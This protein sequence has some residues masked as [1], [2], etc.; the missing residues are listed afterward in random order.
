MHVICCDEDT[1]LERYDEANRRLRECYNHPGLTDLKMN[2]LNSLIEGYGVEAII[3]PDDYSG[4]NAV[5][6]VNMG[7]TYTSTICHDNSTGEFTINCWGDFVETDPERFG[8]EY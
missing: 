7:D 1:L 2:V 6:Y 3:H 5:E 8:L 4:S